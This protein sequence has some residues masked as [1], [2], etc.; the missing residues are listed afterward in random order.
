MNK[1]ETQD[2]DFESRVY[3]VGYLIV[4]SVVQEK[5]ADIVAGIQEELSSEDATVIAEGE[6]RLIDLA[7][8]M[9]HVVAN[10]KAT[11]GQGYFGWIKFE[12]DPSATKNIH[13]ALEKNTD[14]IRFII[15]KTEK[16]DLVTP[17][18]NVLTKEAEERFRKDKEKEAPA[19]K[20]EEKPVVADDK[21]ASEEDIDETIDKLIVD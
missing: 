15:I 4:P 6:P 12:A 5:V 16:E 14:I 2:S 3:E 17:V 10:K 21:S 9:A 18:S 8:D 19:K 13:E 7:Y 1:V 20:R 11:H